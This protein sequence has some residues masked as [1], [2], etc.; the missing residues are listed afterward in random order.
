MAVVPQKLLH[1]LPHPDPPPSSAAHSPFIGECLCVKVTFYLIKPNSRV[2]WLTAHHRCVSMYLFPILLFDTSLKRS[3]WPAETV[4][5]VDTQWRRRQK[6]MWFHMHNKYL[7]WGFDNCLLPVKLPTFLPNS[8]FMSIQASH[9][10]RDRFKETF[11]CHDDFL[12]RFGFETIK[13]TLNI[14]ESNSFS[15]WSL[16]IE[17]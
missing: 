7:S 5:R 1:H 3:S 14:T 12:T 15:S 11:H 9:Q 4:L 17:M 6:H 8:F 10:A 16:H 13:L 2:S